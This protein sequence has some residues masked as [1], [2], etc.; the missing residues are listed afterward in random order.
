M[1]WPRALVYVASWLLLTIFYVA[2]EPPSP[3]VARPA[4]ESP[5]THSPF[6]L[7]AGEVSEV[8]LEAGGSR[9][10]AVR[11]EGRWQVREPAGAA[12]PADLI[13]A[14][15]SA[16]LDSDRAEVIRLPQGRAAEFGL[17][18]PGAR[19][20]LTCADGRSVDVELGTRNPAQ[21]AVYARRDGSSDVV[22]L[23]VDVLYYLDLVMKA[24]TA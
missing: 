19:I 9:V 8:R 20:V 22:L 16:V 5:R 10:D 13:S 2:T 23:G 15:V 1:T 11:V 24:A 18:H 12:V 21:T 4:G 14:V 17:L 3:T 6:E 7:K